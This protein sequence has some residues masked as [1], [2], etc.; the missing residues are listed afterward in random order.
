MSEVISMA[1]ASHDST[2]SDTEEML[3]RALRDAQHGTLR[4]VKAV[5][6]VLDEGTNHDYDWSV[7]CAN[8]RRSETI[9]LLS[10]VIANSCRELN[11]G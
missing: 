10:V 6:I 4:G 5:L 3:T 7:R 1:E 11:G 8:M 9:A 2:Y